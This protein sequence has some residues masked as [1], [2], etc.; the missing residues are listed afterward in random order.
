[1]VKLAYIQHPGLIPILVHL[2]LKFTQ[3]EEVP[4]GSSGGQHH[5]R[6]KALAQT[7][8]TNRPDSRANSLSAPASSRSPASPRS[9]RVHLRL[10]SWVIKSRPHDDQQIG[11]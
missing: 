7:A 10:Q 9:H 3:A 4:F 11:T 8:G 1:M 2:Y 5:H 6:E